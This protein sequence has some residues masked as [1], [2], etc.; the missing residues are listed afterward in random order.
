MKTEVTAID[1]PSIGDV[2]GHLAALTGSV[3]TPTL[4]RSTLFLFAIAAGLSVA[5]VYFAQPLLDA[6]SIQFGFNTASVGLVITVTQI[7]YALGL[8]LIV[9]LGDWLDRRRLVLSQLTLSAVALIV[10]SFATS[11][12]TLLIAMFLV[13]LFAVVVQVLVAFAASLALSEQRGSAVGTVTGGV[14]LGIL[15]ARTIAGVL[16]DVAGWR[17]VYLGSAVLTFLLACSL[18]RVLPSSPVNDASRSYPQ[19]LFSVVELFLSS[20]ILRIRAYIALLLFAS[21]GTLWTSLVLSLSSSPYSLSRTAIGLFGLAGMAG[22]IAAGRAGRMADRGRGQWTTGI[23]LALLL[24][25]WWPIGYLHRSLIALTVGIVILDFAVQAVHVTNQSMI[26]AAHP[27][28]RS[29]V[30]AVYM[31]FYS[32]G[33]GIGAIASTKVYAQFGWT[34]VCVLGISISTIAFVF[35]AFTAFVSE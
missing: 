24:G 12:A 26:F 19:L 15:L 18:Y 30:V 34:G 3:G 25:S 20:R 10:V 8:F 28:A 1:E 21:F 27:A 7:G 13:G 11:K 35:W 31:I 17:S 22:A 33:S 6:L 5:N 14:V 2:H 16:S 9:P 29:R 32:I 4:K 23:G